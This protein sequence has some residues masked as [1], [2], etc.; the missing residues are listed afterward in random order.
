[1]TETDEEDAALIAGLRERDG[2]FIYRLLLRAVLIILVVTWLI[3]EGAGTSMGTW[4]AG[5]FGSIT[6]G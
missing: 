2:R 1:M 4:V 3:M 5:A 6:G